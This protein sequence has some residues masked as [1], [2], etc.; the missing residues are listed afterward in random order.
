MCGIIGYV[1]RRNAQPILV[2]GLKR[3]EYRG[4]DSAGLALL[5]DAGIRIFRSRHHTRHPRFDQRV[6]AGRCFPMMATRLQRYIGDSAF[7]C[8]TR[9]P[10]RFGLGMRAPT[11]T[12]GTASQNPAVADQNASN[13]RIGP[14][15][16]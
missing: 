7:R 16:A 4:Y 13:S 14:G 2:E 6:C 8:R 11:R 1:G 15:L 5:G 12:G 9:P 3:L 10:Q